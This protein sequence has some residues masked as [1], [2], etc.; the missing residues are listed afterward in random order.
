MRRSLLAPIWRREYAAASWNNN[1]NNNNAMTS[2]ANL[3]P[4]RHSTSPRQALKELA[5]DESTG[6]VKRQRT[7]YG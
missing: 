3:Q 6:D 2:A 5:V 1:N 4:R 7:S